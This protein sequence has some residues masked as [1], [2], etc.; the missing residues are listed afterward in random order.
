MAHMGNFGLDE[1]LKGESKMISTID[2]K[3]KAEILKKGS[4]CNNLE[5]ER[6]NSQE[7]NQ[8]KICCCDV[9]QIGTT[10]HDKSTS[11]P[12]LS[13]TEVLWLQDG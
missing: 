10:V 8:R 11:K 4:E 13:E 12:Y 6:S 9:V 5:F 1:A 2:E 7:S 3:E